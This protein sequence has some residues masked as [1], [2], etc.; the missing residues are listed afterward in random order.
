MT[1]NDSDVWG[2]EESSELEEQ[3]SIISMKITLLS[4]SIKLLKR[5]MA[6][7]EELHIDLQNDRLF[8]AELVHRFKFETELKIAIMRKLRDKLID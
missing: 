4:Y 8:L 1:F 3:L 2:L 5:L 7:A 6:R